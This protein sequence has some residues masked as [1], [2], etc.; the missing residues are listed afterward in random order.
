MN[1]PQKPLIVYSDAKDF[2]VTPTKTEPFFVV[3][4]DGL[5]NP[6]D[7]SH[8]LYLVALVH[9][10]KRKPTR[11]ITHIRRIFWCYREQLTEP[12]FAALV[13][14]LIILNHRGQAISRKMVSGARSRLTPAQQAILNAALA[15]PDKDMSLL[16]GNRFSVLSK[17]LEGTITVIEKIAE[18]DFSNHDPLQLAEDAIEYCQLDEAMDILEN[19]IREQ[20]DRLPLHHALL[21][22]YQSIHERPRFEKMATELTAQGVLPDDWDRLKDYFEG[23]PNQHAG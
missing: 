9:E 14:F 5:L 10:I 2:D 11:L 12:L 8:K 19:A 3:T 17:G 21:S 4:T 22:L 6:I 7:S 15:D 20:P 23:Y 18:S 16:P 1:R 13:D